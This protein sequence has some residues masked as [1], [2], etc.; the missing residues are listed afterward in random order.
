MKR[1]TYESFFDKIIICFEDVGSE[2]WQFFW[3]CPDTDTKSDFICV[4]RR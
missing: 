2:Y 3:G 4:W 1:P